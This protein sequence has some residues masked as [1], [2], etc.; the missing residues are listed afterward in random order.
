MITDATSASCGEVA[1]AN[2][3]DLWDVG[4]R[5]IPFAEFRVGVDA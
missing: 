1:D 5:R 3:R 2:I 4:I